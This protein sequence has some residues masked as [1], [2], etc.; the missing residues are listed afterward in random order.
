MGQHSPE[1][2][3][4]KDHVSVKNGNK[5]RRRRVGQI[6]PEPEGM[7]EIAGLEVFFVALSRCVIDVRIGLGFESSHRGGQLLRF[8]IIGQDNTQPM[9]RVI[10]IDG[11]THGIEDSFAVLATRQN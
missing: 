4:I 8:A 7:V 11:T 9:R 3:R 6:G 2:I 1:S 10:G 5:V